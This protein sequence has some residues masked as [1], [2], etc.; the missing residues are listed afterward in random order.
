MGCNVGVDGLEMSMVAMVLLTMRL[1]SGARPSEE[2]GKNDDDEEDDKE[3]E[4][5]EEEEDDNDNA[6]NLC[7][8]FS[9]NQEERVGHWERGCED[10][11]R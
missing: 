4:E 9:W 6:T 8:I 1:P 5:E 7:K 11:L 2:N 10:D 3:E